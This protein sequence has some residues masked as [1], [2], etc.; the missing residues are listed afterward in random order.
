MLGGGLAVPEARCF[1]GGLGAERGSA[2]FA[3][4]LSVCFEE[5]RGVY[6]LP[7]VGWGAELRTAWELGQGIHMPLG[8]LALGRV[9]RLCF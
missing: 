3:Q 5:Q 6:P 2:S 1:S 8:S 9:S 7:D 4:L